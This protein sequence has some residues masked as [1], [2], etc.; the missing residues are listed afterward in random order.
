MHST[1]FYMAQQVQCLRHLYR[2]TTRAV[3]LQSSDGL[4]SYRQEKTG[5]RFELRASLRPGLLSTVC[6]YQR[7][8]RTWSTGFSMT[9]AAQGIGQPFL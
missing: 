9:T 2:D 8:I 1:T 7:T 6:Y 3:C 4:R 5:P